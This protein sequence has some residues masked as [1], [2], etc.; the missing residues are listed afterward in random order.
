MFRNVFVMNQGTVIRVGEND[1]FLIQ[2]SSFSN[3]DIFY[4]L[5]VSFK[6]DYF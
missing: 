4:E 3:V 1:N 2:N 6:L 5:V